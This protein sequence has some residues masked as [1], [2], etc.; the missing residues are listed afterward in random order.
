MPEALHHEADIAQAADRTSDIGELAV[1]VAALAAEHLDETPELLVEAFF[2]K[3]S[4]APGSLPP[5]SLP[6]DP[7]RLFA[8]LSLHFQSTVA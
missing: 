7:R 4:S 3:R 1:T 8:K 5:R 6:A 2:A